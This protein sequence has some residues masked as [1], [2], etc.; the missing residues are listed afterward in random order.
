MRAKT[1]YHCPVCGNPIVGRSDKK[2]CDDYCR[3]SHHYEMNGSKNKLIR[4]MN[5]RLKKNRRIL[6]KI[7]L[8]GRF[9]CST[10]ELLFMGFDFSI[11][12][13]IFMNDQGETI[14]YCYDYGYVTRE[15]GKV[16]LVK[17]EVEEWEM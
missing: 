11:H 12:T 16:E 1:Q 14:Y 8:K 6:N 13:S 10:Q 4:T 15:E 2:Y 17:R 3:S 7:M 9:C 5:S